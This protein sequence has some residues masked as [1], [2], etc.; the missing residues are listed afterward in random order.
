MQQEKSKIPKTAFTSNT[1]SSYYPSLLLAET[2][3]LKL[4]RQNTLPRKSDLVWPL[5]GIG[6]AVCI[7]RNTSDELTQGCR[8][9]ASL[10]VTRCNHLCMSQSG[11]QR[12]VSCTWV[13]D[14][15]TDDTESMHAGRHAHTHRIKT[16]KHL[17]QRKHCG[18]SFFDMENRNK[19][20]ATLLAA[21]GTRDINTFF[22]AHHT[23]SCH[24]T[25][26]T[27][28]L[29]QLIRSSRKCKCGPSS[30]KHTK[31]QMLTELLTG[32]IM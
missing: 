23:H 18:C 19:S 8:V 5:E 15:Q 32:T 17:N 22:Y 26:G 3:T 11:K 6:R 16:H 13:L 28:I 2:H 27:T 31:L 25:P 7:Q 1:S 12:H 21:A 20:Y 10:H 9:L 14:R 30:R 24:S 4:A 29:L